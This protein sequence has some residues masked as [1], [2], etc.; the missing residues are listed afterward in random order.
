MSAMACAG[1][2]HGAG[3]LGAAGAR[4][5]RNRHLGDPPARGGG[6]STI[7]SGYPERRSRSA[8]CEQVGAAGGAHRPQVVQPGSGAPGELAGQPGVGDPRVRGPRRPRG[9][10]P[11]PEHQVGGADDDRRDDRRQVG[12]IQRAVAVAE[13]HQSVPWPPRGR[14]RTRPEA[15][16]GLGDHR[17]A[18]R[19]R[20]GRT[21]RRPSR[22]RRRSRGSRPGA[23]RARTGRA[24]ASSRQGSTT[25]TATPSSLEPL[26]GWT[27]GAGALTRAYGSRTAAS[28]MIG[29]RRRRRT[30]DHVTARVLVVDDDPTVAEV[31]RSYLARAGFDVE[32]AADGP[33]ALAVAARTRPDLVV[34]DLMLPGLY[35]PR[36]VRAGCA[37]PRPD[38]AGRHA[39]RPRRGERP[40]GRASSRAP[41]TT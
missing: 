40:G 5:V 37:A 30:L 12:E 13:R 26:T 23:G 17:R 18:V 24:A 8:E 25:S 35:G 20:H 1:A 36:G 29:E 10:Y 19:G 34:L 9:R 7:S 39:H 31:V 11:P 28:P 32:H 33:T 4:R 27:L 22:C 14:R 2:A 41:T 21:G 15:A 6:R 16:P 3:H 38:L